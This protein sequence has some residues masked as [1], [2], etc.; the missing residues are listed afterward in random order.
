M[1]L[2]TLEKLVKKLIRSTLKNNTL[3]YTVQA[4][5]S[6]LN[7]GKLEY[8]A[9]ISSPAQG[10]QPITFIYDDFN[11]IK[12]ALELAIEELD[13]DKVE[14]AFHENRINMYKNK[15]EQHQD[16]V[17]VLNDPER[18]DEDRDLEHIPMEEVDAE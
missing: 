11:T 1:Q 2:Q 18:S 14:V 3:D 12:S 10:V 13:E 5:M 9:Q 15:I 4:T 7:P 16:R 6:S 17:N 8:A